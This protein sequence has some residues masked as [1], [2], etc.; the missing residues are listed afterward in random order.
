MS[1]DEAYRQWATKLGILRVRQ[2]SRPSAF[3]AGHE[4]GRREGYAEALR[5]ARL[6]LQAGADKYQ[7]QKEA[8]EGGH[9]HLD[10]LRR[11][12]HKARA[13]KEAVDY[14]R[15]LERGEQ[16]LAEAVRGLEES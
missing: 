6:T 1:A 10:E 11:F 4:I 5:N 15:A 9:P 2:Q 13:L 3:R 14:V 8:E 7:M 16:P 12:G